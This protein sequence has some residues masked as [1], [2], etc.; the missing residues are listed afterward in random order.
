[1]A[2]VSEDLRAAYEALNEGD[3]RPLAALFAPE[4]VWR[5]IGH[6]FLWWRT[7]PS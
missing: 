4:T 6:G 7:A 3:A 5:A 1:M 2:A